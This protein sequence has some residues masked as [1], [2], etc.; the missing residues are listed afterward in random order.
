MASLIVLGIALG[1][2][3]IAA[4]YVGWKQ[5][6]RNW[7]LVFVGWSL[8]LGCL[9]VWGQLSG[10]D[11]GPALGLVSIVITALL[12]ILIIAL[13]SPVKQRREPR[14]RQ[15]DLGDQASVW[16]EGL[17]VT[18]SVL[19]IVFVGLVV[20]IAACS[21]LFMASRSL[22]VEESANLTITMFAFP[23]SW[24]GLATYIGYSPSPMSKA[25]TLLMG[26]I[27]SGAIIAVSV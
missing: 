14:I 24:A 10:I 2:A 17:S 9:M 27:L 15:R 26:L 25:F 18:A 7:L 5:K 8:L 13:R 22:G 23:L 3:G 11:K 20:S 19:A 4:L 21:A 16:H 6:K 12:A 1:A